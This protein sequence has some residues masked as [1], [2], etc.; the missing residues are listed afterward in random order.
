VRVVR[1]DVSFGPGRHVSTTTDRLLRQGFFLPLPSFVS[2]PP[3]LKS[4]PQASIS[5]R[6]EDMAKP[7]SAGRDKS[8]GDATRLTGKDLRRKEEAPNASSG[9][10]D[11]YARQDLNLRG[12]SSN[13]C[14]DKDLGN[15]QT[16]VL[17]KVGVNGSRNAQNSPLTSPWLLRRGTSR[18]QGGFRGCKKNPVLPSAS[19]VP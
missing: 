2:R 18:S 15:H 16:G 13:D 11:W 8:D 19:R 3:F 9:Q 17:S 6:I 14:K 10:G 1:R 7:A 5:A 4:P 12:Q